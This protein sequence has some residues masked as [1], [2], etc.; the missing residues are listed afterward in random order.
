MAV[1]LVLLLACGPKSNLDGDSA[2]TTQESSSDGA[3]A[4]GTVTTG[5]SPTTAPN[6]TSGPST[7][8]GPN[9]T[10][11]P[12]TTSSA[13]TDTFPLDIGVSTFCGDFICDEAELASCTCPEDCGSCALPQG[14]QGCPTD[15]FGGSAVKG[16]TPFGALDGHTAFFA[17][18][19]LG[20]IS[21]SVLRLFIF[22]TSVD[23]DAAK[24]DPYGNVSFALRLEPPWNQP[25]WLNN[26]GII[27]GTITRNDDSVGH[28]ALLTIQGSAG[29][30][31]QFDPNDPPR[32]L[33]LV[34]A[35][36]PNREPIEGPFDG[37]YCEAFNSIVIPE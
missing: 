11:G 27:W 9:T 32:L 34:Q 7:T 30:W 22:D 31:Q 18:T 6:P 16:M 17:W 1:A 5:P 28:Q 25:E 35:A 13:M 12:V 21:F 8:T 4:T 20:D 2:S 33:G 36:G 15:W 3:T 10:T 29:N 23:L 19:G 37:V 14:L 26:Q 24:Q